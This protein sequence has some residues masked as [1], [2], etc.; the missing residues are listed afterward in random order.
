MCGRYTLRAR[1]DDL[2]PL[3]AVEPEPGF[4]WEPRY[5]IPPTAPVPIVRLVDGR[6]RVSL[7]KWGL[8]PSWAKDAKTAFSTINARADTVATKPTFRTAYKK[9]RCLVLADGYFEWETRGKT[10]LPWL[11]EIAG[12]QPFAFAGLWEAWHG[13][14]EN[15]PP[16][17]TCTIITT[18]PNELAGT[19]HDRMPVILHK[20]DYQAWLQGEVIPL[21]AWEADRMTAKPVSTYVNSVNNQGVQCVAPREAA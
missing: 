5:N 7:A 20:D 1:G 21:V 6:R 18:D 9:R 10:K 4:L 17:E 14:G 19:F 3:F 16:V 11:Y 8:I 13:N 2:I 12:G 15:N